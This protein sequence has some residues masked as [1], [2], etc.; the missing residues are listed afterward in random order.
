M[1][2]AELDEKVEHFFNEMRSRVEAHAEQV[3]FRLERIE[4]ALLVYAGEAG[5]SPTHAASELGRILR[6]TK[7]QFVDRNLEAPAL[8]LVPDQPTS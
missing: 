6:L 8:T 5:S 4:Q 1:T 7:E 3:N 2:T